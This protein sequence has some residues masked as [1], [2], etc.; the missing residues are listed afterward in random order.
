[1][2]QNCI[3]TALAIAAASI[4]IYVGT[5]AFIVHQIGACPISF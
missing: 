3:R 4:W 2:T 1:M 5:V